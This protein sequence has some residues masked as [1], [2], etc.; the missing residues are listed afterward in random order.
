MEARLLRFSK[1]AGQ[2]QL[3]EG[4]KEALLLSSYQVSASPRSI[5][6]HSRHPEDFLNY[7]TSLMLKNNKDHGWMVHEVGEVHPVTLGDGLGAL[8]VN[9]IVVKKVE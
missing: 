3:R 4:P 8:A 1:R 7:L 9:V 6:D 2:W 5:L